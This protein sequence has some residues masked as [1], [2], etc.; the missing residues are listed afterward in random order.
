MIGGRIR[1]YGVLTFGTYEKSQTASY[2]YTKEDVM[3]ERELFDLLSRMDDAAF[4]VDQEGIIC[5]WNKAAEEWFQLP[6]QEALGHACD[7][8]MDGQDAVGAQVCSHDCA[9]RELCRRSDR[10]RAFDLNAKISDGQ[11]KWVN[12][13]TIV[14]RNGRTG[15][16]LTIHTMRDINDR[17]EIENSTHQILNAMASLTGTS[18]EA[19]LQ[20]WRKEVPSRPL[21]NQEIQV[22]RMLSEGLSTQAVSKRLKISG[23]TVRNHIQHILTKL[24]AHSR[25][26]AV[27]IARR[28]GF[29]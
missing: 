28:Q 17:K 6:A 14:S 26:E 9:V 2:H 11:R 23:T 3:L 18:G 8:I 7:E 22:V 13:S 16:F 24:A 1:S 25:L 21:T 10:I 19:I 5:F 27:Q 20:R 12:V 15:R 29:I 4:A